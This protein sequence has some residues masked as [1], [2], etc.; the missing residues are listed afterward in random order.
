MRVFAS[1]H[2][3][4]AALHH[5]AHALDAVRLGVEAGLPG[6]GAPPVRWAAPESWHVT[7]AFYGEVPDGAVPELEEGL[8]GL[9]THQRPFDL[10]LRGAGVFAHRTLWVGLG[11]DADTAARLCAQAREVGASVLGRAEARERARPHLTVGRVAQEVRAGRS[12][13]RGPRAEGRAGDADPLTAPVRAL[14]VYE[15]PSWTVAEVRLVRSDLGQGRGGSALHTD[16]AR[17]PL[18]GH[19]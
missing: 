16:V 18:G 9:A 2:P 3:S 8:A 10:R 13:R 14:G 15:G 11:G 12:R 5:L 4:D 19:R 6:S 1:L 17:F 7:L